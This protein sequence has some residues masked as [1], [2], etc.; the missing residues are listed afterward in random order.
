MKK[1]KKNRKKN[2]NLRER[3]LRV[4]KQAFSIISTSLLTCAMS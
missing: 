2:Q 3:H 4:P 1:Q